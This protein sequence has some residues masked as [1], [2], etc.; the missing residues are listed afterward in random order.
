M[1]TSDERAGWVLLAVTWLRVALVPVVMVLILQ[2]PTHPVTFL[3]GSALFLIASLTDLLDGFLARRWART[4][5]FGSFLDTT[6]DKLL[7]TGPLLAL[8][9]VDRMSVWIAFILIGREVLV[10]G[11]K[12]MVAAGGTS[13][14]ASSL[15]KWK[16]V[17]QFIAIAS[18]IAR[19]DVLLVGLHP[20]EWAMLV[21]TAI[22]IWSAVDYLG[23]F[24]SSL[25]G[26][27]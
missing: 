1:S 14:E 7:I 15:G 23:R 8:I 22:T 18:A 17:V 11:L 26:R 13:V 25:T 20:D 6:A 10:L 21:A 9:A 12:G 19:V 24:R 16:A 2:G 5:T 3:V 27:A 4:S